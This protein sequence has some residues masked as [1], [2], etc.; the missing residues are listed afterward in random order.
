HGREQV[1][2]LLDPA[3]P[4]ALDRLRATL[5]EDGDVHLDPAFQHSVR[6]F[7]LDSRDRR[8]GL[9]DDRVAPLLSRAEG[10]LRSVPGHY[11]TDFVGARMGKARGLRFLAQELGVGGGTPLAL[12]V[13][14]TASD[15]EMLRLARLGVAP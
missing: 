1:R 13:G 10:L 8:R 11:Q 6:A 4:G 15:L 9:P 12:A 3:E 7:V 2:S 14:D 5:A